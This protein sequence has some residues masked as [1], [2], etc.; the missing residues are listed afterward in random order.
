MGIVD[1]TTFEGAADAV[2]AG[3]RDMLGMVGWNEAVQDDHYESVLLGSLEALGR[4]H[5]LSPDEVTDAL[6]GMARRRYAALI[7]EEGVEVVCEPMLKHG[8]P[9]GPVVLMLNHDS[10]IRRGLANHNHS[11]KAALGLAGYNGLF[12]GGNDD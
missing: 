1:A 6:A 10:Q 2:L 12:G 8:D 3:A 9:V 5:G 11:Q 4:L 7:G